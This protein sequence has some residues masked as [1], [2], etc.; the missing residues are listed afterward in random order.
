LTPRPRHSY[1]WHTGPQRR[2]L[3]TR[4]GTLNS[5]GDPQ[6]P[7]SS[8]RD[9]PKDDAVWQVSGPAGVDL[10]RARYVRQQFPRHWHDCFVICVNERGAH[11]S[12]YAGETV[13]LPEGCV[14]IVPP[15]EVHTGRPVPGAPWYYRAMY[16]SA[17]QMAEIAA[18]VGLPAGTMPA[19]PGLCLPD[20]MLADAFL[21]A[22]RQ[23]EA[24]ADALERDTIIAELL[25]AVVRRH[26]AWPRGRL[27]RLVP[28][29]A[30]R[31]VEEYIRQ[32]S[33]R[34]ITLDALAGVAGVSRHAVLRAFRRYVGIAPY[35][36][37]TQVRVEHA[38]R[39]LRQ[40]TPIAAVS[41]RVGFADQSHLTRHFK[42]LLGVTPGAFARAA[43]AHEGPPAPIVQDL[44][45]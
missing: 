38:K 37:V 18:E 32:S 22:H 1:I 39:L 2:T 43:R 27:D 16:V 7:A 9:D 33:A 19:F 41:Q 44:H 6:V 8:P 4:G 35:E 10:L 42:R 34:R 20:P 17:A 13:I 40:G 21:R 30:V 12:W 36:Y 24:S 11:A 45:Q 23:C 31:R 3:H 28:N 5:L 14:T 15:G 26:A 29:A 25:L